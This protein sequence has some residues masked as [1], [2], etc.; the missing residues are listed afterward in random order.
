M[1]ATAAAGVPPER[2]DQGRRRRLLAA[3][4]AADHDGAE[5]RRHA[6]AGDRRHL[7]GV[8]ALARGGR[9]RAGARRPD[10]RRARPGHGR[11]AGRRG[12]PP[13]ATR[14]QRQWL[15]APAGGGRRSATRLVAAPARPLAAPADAG[16]PV[17]QGWRALQ[18]FPGHEPP[19]NL[20]AP[21]RQMERAAPQDRHPRMDPL[22]RPRHRDRRQ[23]RPEEPRAAD[24][25][26]RRVQAR[27]R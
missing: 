10:P 20:A 16:C 17:G 26:Q 1:R 13:R 19:R 18:T 4:R 11:R 23:R 21:R 12:A 15:P 2:A 7:V 25:R 5:P 6:R 9:R 22:R 24:I 14:S 3:E 8:R 27:R